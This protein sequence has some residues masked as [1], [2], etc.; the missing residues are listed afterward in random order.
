MRNEKDEQ[1]H[2]LRIQNL[3]L[4][5]R[6]QSMTLLSR[7]LCSLGVGLGVRE[8]TCLSSAPS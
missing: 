6:L 8:I 5:I 2:S 1:S 3:Q 7:A 4:R